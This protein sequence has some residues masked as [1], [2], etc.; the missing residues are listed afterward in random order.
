[1][2]KHSFLTVCQQTVPTNIALTSMSTATVSVRLGKKNLIKT[3]ALA[4]GLVKFWTK[5]LAALP[6]CGR[7]YRDYVRGQGSWVNV[8]VSMLG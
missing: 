6:G 3:I 7:K 8:E 4:G 2:L 5:A 1:M